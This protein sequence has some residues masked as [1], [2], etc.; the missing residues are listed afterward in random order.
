MRWDNQSQRMGRFVF[1]I[2]VYDNLHTA[3][4]DIHHLH[5][6]HRY[7]HHFFSSLSACYTLV[8]VVYVI[9]KIKIF[10]NRMRSDMRCHLIFNIF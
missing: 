3:L 10:K 1:R 4:C 7:L 8:Y 6:L 9:S 2:F 5:H